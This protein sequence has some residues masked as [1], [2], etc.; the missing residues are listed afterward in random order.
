M[1]DDITRAATLSGSEPTMDLVDI[2]AN[3]THESFAHDLH[4]VMARAARTGVSQMVVTGSSAAESAACVRLAHAHA[5]HLFATAGVHPHLASEWDSAVAQSIAQLLADDSVVAIGETGLDFNRNFSPPEDQER[6]F[7]AHLEMAAKFGKPLFLHE[8]DAFARFHPILREHRRALGAVVV[9]CFTGDS[10][11]LD[12]YLDLDLHIGITGWICDERRGLHLRDL[13]ARIPAERL[14][15][16]TD[17]P[18]LLPRD[19]RPRPKSRRNEPMHLLHILRQVALDRGQEP[20][21]CARQTTA[22]A[23]AFFALPIPLHSEEV[24]RHVAV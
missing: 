23:R 13:V 2:G 16:E 8:R 6:S 19:L 12:A 22:T 17:S 3:L 4:E 5:H 10:D 18:Y 7:I 21:E 11:A 20:H 9:H 24:T 1:M 14:M 15:L